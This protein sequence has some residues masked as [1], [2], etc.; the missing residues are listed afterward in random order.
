MPASALPTA[1]VKDMV[2]FMFMP[3]SCAAPASSLTARIALPMRVFLTS[4][5]SA[6][7]DM[8]ATTTVMSAVVGMAIRPS[9]MGVSSIKV[10]ITCAFAPNI[11]CATFSKK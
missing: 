3:I 4:T 2:L 11:S 8:P 6:T 10:G 1:K 9:C 5:F 7:I